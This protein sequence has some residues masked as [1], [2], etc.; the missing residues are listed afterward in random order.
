MPKLIKLEIPV[1]DALEKI[2][3]KNETRSQAVERLIN[4]YNV[5]MVA[6]HILPG[7]NKRRENS[8]TTPR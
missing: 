7:E 8:E 3:G 4:F 6:S 5:V 1:Y 2:R